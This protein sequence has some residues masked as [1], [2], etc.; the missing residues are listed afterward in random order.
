LNGVV[1]GSEEGFEL[2]LSDNLSE[3]AI[4][5]QIKSKAIEEQVTSDAIFGGQGFRINDKFTKSMKIQAKSLN[6]SKSKLNISI[7]K[8]NAAGMLN[9]TLT[10]NYVFN[11]SLKSI[12]YISNSQTKVEEVTVGDLSRDMIIASLNGAQMEGRSDV[13]WWSNNH[14]IT[15]QEAQSF[16]QDETLSKAGFKNIKY[17]Y[18]TI[19]YQDNNNKKTVDMVAIYF[20]NYDGGSGYSW[21][22]DSVI[23]SESSKFIY[24]SKQAI[25]GQ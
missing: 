11:V 4:L 9:T 19:T 6:D 21:K 10:G 15:Q 8:E 25:K 20:L 24:Y 2:A 5:T 16:K 3:E 13:F 23:S 12:T 14:Q 1:K 17:A 22:L 18:G 7:R